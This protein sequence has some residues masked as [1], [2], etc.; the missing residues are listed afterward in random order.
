MISLKDTDQQKEESQYYSWS[1][2]E[3]LDFSPSNINFALDVGC[4]A[5]CFGQLLKESRDCIV[6]GVEPFETAAQAASRKLSRVFNSCFNSELNFEGQEFDCIFFNDVLEH[7]EN[8]YSALDY[9]K[10]VLA[11]KGHVVASIP[12][13]L[14][15]PT[16]VRILKTQD[17]RYE[18]SGILDRT[19]LRFFTQKS[20][21]RMFNECGFE[22]VKMQGINPTSNKFFK[23]LNFAL[24]N[25][26]E[27]MKYRQFLVLARL[28]SDS[29][30]RKLSQQL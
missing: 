15:F 16:V 19:H 1:R 8:P 20:I 26:I 17:W 3:I 29:G 7:L 18:E 28:K 30:K 9:C 22:V 24:G 27:S 5:G 14:E 25:K 13:I 2:P 10:S 21:S 11:E 12:N 4:G 23:I 6:W